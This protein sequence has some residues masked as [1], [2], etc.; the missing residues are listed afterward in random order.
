MN[1]RYSYNKCGVIRLENSRYGLRHM[2]IVSLLP[3]LKVHA[4]AV[5]NFLLDRVGLPKT[6][7]GGSVHELIHLVCYGPQS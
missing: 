1:K 6:N 7:A 3:S 4:V 2:G 5:L